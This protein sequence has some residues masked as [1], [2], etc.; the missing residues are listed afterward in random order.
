FAE[1][2]E[3]E[4]VMAVLREYHAA[5][6]ALILEYEGTLERF[7]GDGMMVFFNDP[8]AIPDAALRAVRMAVA[9]RDRIAELSRGWAARGFDLHHGIGIA[10]GYATLGAIGF[11]GRWDYGAIGTVTNMAA[12]LCAEAGIDEVLVSHRVA[13]SVGDAAKFGETR[14]LKLRGFH[15]PVAARNV[16]AIKPPGA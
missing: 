6:G 7:T 13:A 3:P 10:Q 1:L 5:T 16:R 14:S 11:E 8:I 4:E 12:R 2:S 9:I 15:R